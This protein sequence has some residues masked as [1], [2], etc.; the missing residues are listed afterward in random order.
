MIFRK[1]SQPLQSA[2]LKEKNSYPLFLFYYTLLHHHPT[3]WEE[4]SLNLLLPVSIVFD[5]HGV[6][7]FC[8]IT[9]GTLRPCP[10]VSMK[11]I[12]KK[13]PVQ[14]FVC[15]GASTCR[16]GKRWMAIDAAMW[17]A[18]WNKKGWKR[19]VVCPIVSKLN[20]SWLSQVLPDRIMFGS[21]PCCTLSILHDLKPTILLS[22]PST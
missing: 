9:I 14:E 11:N 20:T 13:I 1:V 5:Y 19:V 10:I 15:H 12:F 6:N 7:S 8:I 21:W 22:G 2:M 3:Y 16:A 4:L 18:S 17:Y